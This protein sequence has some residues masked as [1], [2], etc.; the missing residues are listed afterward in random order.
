MDSFESTVHSKT[1]L[2]RDS[3]VSDV[4][5]ETALVAD[6]SMLEKYGRQ[7]LEAYLYSVM[8][9]VSGWSHREVVKNAYI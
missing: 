4:T 6:K 7:N 3:L 5:I 1:R 2:R 8:G 9:V